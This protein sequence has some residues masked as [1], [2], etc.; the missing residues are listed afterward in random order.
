[1]TDTWTLVH[2]ER[3]ALIDDLATLDDEQWES[4]SLAAGW[5]VHDV[6]A[7]LVDNAM[8]T[9]LGLVV[10]MARARFDFDRQNA[11]GV[12]AHKGATPAQTLARLRQVADRTSG[13]P[14]A[15]ASRLVEEIAHGEDIRRP[16]GIVR[17]YPAEAVCAAVEHQ[18]RTPEALGGAKK[19]AGRVRL[20]ADDADLAVGSGP[21]VR[22]PALELLMLTTGRPSRADYRPTP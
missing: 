3:H 13:P 15:L 12:A 14:V 21:E 11:N 5:T 6:A 2:A 16:L 20:V 9:P 22:A 8:A 4:D 10:A 18:V 7:H 19:L 1:M 17:A